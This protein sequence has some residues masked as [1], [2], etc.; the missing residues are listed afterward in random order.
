MLGD[1]PRSRHF[2]VIQTQHHINLTYCSWL[3]RY[4][5]CDTVPVKRISS[6]NENVWLV[7][8]CLPVMRFR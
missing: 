2:A 7:L 1:K 4:S 8:S 5:C 6:N 3:C